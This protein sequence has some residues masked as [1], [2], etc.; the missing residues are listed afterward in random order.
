MIRHKVERNHLSSRL[1]NDCAT[2]RAMNLQPAARYAPHLPQRS[3]TFPPPNELRR[4]PSAT[5]IN[6]D[7]HL[8]SSSMP[9]HSLL[10]ADYPQHSSSSSLTAS[11]HLN[12]SPVTQEHQQWSPSSHSDDTHTRSNHIQYYTNQQQQQQQQHQLSPVPTSVCGECSNNVTGQFVRALG[13][14]FHKDCFRCKARPSLPF[15]HNYPSL[16]LRITRELLAARQTPHSHSYISNGELPHSITILLCLPPIHTSF[17][18][19]P[20]LCSRSSI[21]NLSITGIPLSHQAPAPLMHFDLFQI[22]ANRP[23]YHSIPPL[24]SWFLC[25]TVA[26][27][28]VSS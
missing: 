13:A 5:S 17:R 18:E 7:A 16:A 27:Y 20:D 26:D 10:S 2:S 12:R 8:A 25:T 14:V 21:P 23:S 4:S 24:P 19:T 1:A 9:G 3:P 22:E 6:S 11:A 15:A 28:P